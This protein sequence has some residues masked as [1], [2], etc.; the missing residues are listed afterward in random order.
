MIRMTIP[1]GQLRQDKDRPHRAR[2]HQVP[3]LGVLRLG[4]TGERRQQLSRWNEPLKTPKQKSSR[5]SPAA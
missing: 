1:P 4:L 5:K 3:L 2:M